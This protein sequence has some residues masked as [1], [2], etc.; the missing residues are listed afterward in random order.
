M[1]HSMIVSGF[2]ESCSHCNGPVS[3]RFPKTPL[4]CVPR[5]PPPALVATAGLCSPSKALPFLEVSR[6]WITQQEAFGVCL[7]LLRVWETPHGV[8]CA[9]LGHR[10]V[11]VHGTAMPQGHPL[12]C[13]G[14]LRKCPHPAPMQALGVRGR[15]SYCPD[16]AIGRPW[17]LSL[18]PLG[19]SR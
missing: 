12:T 8:A 6:A 19:S 17:A 3:E 7:R 11:A 2:T 13:T 16:H 4:A 15:D 10:G 18:I 1:C 14:F 9:S 5:S